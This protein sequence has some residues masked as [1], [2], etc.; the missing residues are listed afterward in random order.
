MLTITVLQY[1]IC[2]DDQIHC[3]DDY[4]TVNIMSSVIDDARRAVA[5][6]M[7]VREMD[8]VVET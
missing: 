1:S 6:A 2:P 7:A 4:E 8:G 3:A 5:L